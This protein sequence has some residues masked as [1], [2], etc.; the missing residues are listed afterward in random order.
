MYDM[1]I[2]VYVFYT[3]LYIYIL[4]SVVITHDE[5]PGIKR[6]RLKNGENSARTAAQYNDNDGDDDDNIIIL[7]G[8]KT[9][10]QQ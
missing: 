8:T 7:C 9:A 10:G 5:R 6:R 1:A 2:C 3:Y 4:I